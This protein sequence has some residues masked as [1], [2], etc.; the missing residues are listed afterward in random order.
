MSSV[1]TLIA[2]I[3]SERRFEPENLAFR[4]S[5]NFIQIPMILIALMCLALSLHRYFIK[6]LETLALPT[7]SIFNDENLLVV[8]LLSIFEVRTQLCDR[9]SLSHMGVE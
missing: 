8:H 1:K 7:E 5:P 4:A 6:V 2:T 9:L 3:L